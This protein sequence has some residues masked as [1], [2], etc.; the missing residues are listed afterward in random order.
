MKRE[1]LAFIMVW[2]ILFFTIVYKSCS[3]KPQEVVTTVETTVRVDTLR[4]TDTITR[5][6][7]YKVVELKTDTLRIDTAAIIADYFM[8]KSY[9]LKYEDTNA[10]VS[11]EVTI[12]QN[13]IDT[14]IISYEVLNRE[15]NTTITN[16]ITNT[17]PPRWGISLN[18]AL[19]YSIPNSK[20][21]LDL[22]LTVE[23][24]RHRV[25]V[26]FD[27]VNREVSVGYGWQIIKSK[28]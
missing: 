8:Q 6:V 19:N 17:V 15:T 3:S 22:G 7:P 13:R 10:N 1:T 23:A 26:G 18:T 2:L 24:G 27:V 14:V 12:S 16:T 4:H 20:F 5:P 25:P 28:K 11:S 21:G 9:S